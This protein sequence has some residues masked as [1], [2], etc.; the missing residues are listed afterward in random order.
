MTVRLRT[1]RRLRI[2]LIVLAVIL[3]PVAGFL[4]WALTPDGPAP[5]AEG[6][7]RSDGT[8][9]VTTN[10][11]LVFRPKNIKPTTGLVF[12]P[13]AHV[14][15]RSYAPLVY[16]IASAGHLVVIPQMPLNFAILA[17]NTAER[18]MAR[19]PYVKHW[20]VGGH[21]LGGATA[22]KYAATHDVRGL[23]IFAATPP[24]DT[25]LSHRTDLLVTAVFGTGGIGA[26]AA[27]VAKPRLPENTTYV[28]ITGGNHAQF[29]TYD[30]SSPEPPARMRSGL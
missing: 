28:L 21:S 7:L 8:V 25:D 15:P 12:Y 6:F 23:V 14:D 29:G 16:R 17:P 2:L 13:G 30:P 1:D 4:I 5:E 20:A 22:V 9:E 3:L 10:G 18:V 11:E 24:N 19:F 27:A 26:E